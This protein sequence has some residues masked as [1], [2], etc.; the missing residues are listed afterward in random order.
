MRS[1]E[2]DCRHGQLCAYHESDCSV[3][4]T[5]LGSGHTVHTLS[6]MPRLT[7]SAAFC[8]TVQ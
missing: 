7:Q 1:Y 6:Y 4:N 5:A 3:H 8:G 2:I